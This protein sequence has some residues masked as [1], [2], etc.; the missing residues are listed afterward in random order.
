MRSSLAFATGLLLLLAGCQTVPPS[1]GSV[2]GAKRAEVAW[3][4]DLN[5]PALDRDIAAAY[6]ASPD[7]RAVALRMERAEAVVSGA[8]ARM[9]PSLN[10]GFGYSDGRQRNIDFGP[11]DLGPWQSSG[12]LSWEVDLSGKLRA[13]RNS[14]SENR[15]AAVWDYHLARLLLGT[16]IAASRLAL[17]RFNAEAAVVGESLQ[18]SRETE[19]YL[20]EQAGAGLIPEAVLDKQR[21]EVERLVR[22]EL[23]LQRQRDLAVVQLR[24]LRGGSNPGGTTRADFPDPEEL[25]ARPLDELLGS[26]PRL[27]AAEARVRAAFQLEQSARLDLLPSFQINGLV[28][29]RQRGLTERFM[30]WTAQAGPSLSLPVYDPVRLAGIKVRQAEAK[31]AAAN[32]RQ[33]VLEVLEDVDTA[34]INLASRRAQL[35]AARRE[36]RSLER[37]RDKAREQFNAGIISQIDYLDTERRWLEAKRQLAGLR[38]AELKAHLNLIKATGGG[39]I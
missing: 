28:T 32:Y 2:A 15:K 31:L 18:A 9:L 39:R 19:Q 23:D 22:Q 33:A 35:A 25:V 24:T 5:D 8:Q 7:L 11:F 26:H 1:A 29:G 34:R 14:A 3:W 10:L 16:R 30:M 38:Q 37:A 17:Y 4:R 6:A 36:T 20:A 27:L 21:A 13:A 12:G